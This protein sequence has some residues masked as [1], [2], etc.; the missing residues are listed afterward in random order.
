MPLTA[1]REPESHPFLPP[2][3]ESGRYLTLLAAPAVAAVAIDQ[4]Y[5]SGSAKTGR[6]ALVLRGRIGRAA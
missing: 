3:Q 4:A 2:G 1:V 6:G 5:G